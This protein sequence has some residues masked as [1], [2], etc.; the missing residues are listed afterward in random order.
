MMTRVFER[1]HLGD[2]RDAERLAF[3]ILSA[4]QLSTMGIVTRSGTESSTRRAHRPAFNR[5]EIAAGARECP[6]L[7][8]G[9]DIRGHDT[10]R[11]P[12]HGR[13][14]RS[15]SEPATGGDGGVRNQNPTAA[16]EA[17]VHRMDAYF[18]CDELAVLVH[19]LRELIGDSQ[20]H[21]K[22]AFLSSADDVSSDLLETVENAWTTME[23]I[24]GELER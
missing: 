20:A 5:R 14:A 7:F 16:Q 13:A 22:M 4:S 9:V 15:R 6:S 12:S 21:S 23:Q 8:R 1:L 10:Q 17:Y 3:P 11:P 19:R 2:A 24:A 18:I